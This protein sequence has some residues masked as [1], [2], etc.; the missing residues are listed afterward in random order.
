MYETILDILIREYKGENVVQKCDNILNS[1]D[2]DEF[3]VPLL[4]DIK[5]RNCHENNSFYKDNIFFYMKMI[6]LH[7]FFAEFRFWE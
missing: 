4:N 1:L 7:C 6:Q 5:K 3:F 2:I